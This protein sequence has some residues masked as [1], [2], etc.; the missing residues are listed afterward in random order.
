MIPAVASSIDISATECCLSLTLSMVW[1]RF[2]PC[3]GDV[4]AAMLGRLYDRS[5]GC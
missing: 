4:G 1:S 2:T 5:H 3:A